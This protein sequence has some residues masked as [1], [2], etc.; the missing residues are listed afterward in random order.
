LVRV[1]TITFPANAQNQVVLTVN[2]KSCLLNL[3]THAV[4]GCH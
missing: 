4:T 1:V 2:A 3:A